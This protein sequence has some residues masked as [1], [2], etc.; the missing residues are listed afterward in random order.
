MTLRRIVLL[1][2]LTTVAWV[3]GLGLEFGFGR[4]FPLTIEAPPPS[5]EIMELQKKLATQ[6]YLTEREMQEV[7]KEGE[8]I[9]R[10][11][12]AR[13]A[14]ESFR[15]L[16]ARFGMHALW[17]TWLP[18]AIVAL[19]AFKSSA[20]LLPAIALIA[21]L[22]ITRLTS[23]V[24]GIVFASVSVVAFFGKQLVRSRSSAKKE[25]PEG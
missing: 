8:Q 10:D 22:L 2:A 6:G 23:P 9:M 1:M 3:A 11:V 14:N 12:H 16:M 15:D 25:E 24:E 19:Y 4:L 7:Q 5:P 20:D 18:W 21:I 13:Y 17:V